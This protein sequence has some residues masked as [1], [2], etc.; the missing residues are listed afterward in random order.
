MENK[1]ADMLAQK[2]VT[3]QNDLIL[4]ALPDQA[5]LSRVAACQ[6]GCGGPMIYSY[7]EKPF[8]EVYAPEFETVFENNAY[9]IKATQSY[10]ILK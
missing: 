7:D 4:L 2:T 3:A 10:R 1:Y 6:H 9:K 8:L 5:K